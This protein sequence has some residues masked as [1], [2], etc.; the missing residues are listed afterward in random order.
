MTGHVVAVAVVVLAVM[1]VKVDVGGGDRAVVDVAAG[2][3]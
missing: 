1:M 2:G 3:G